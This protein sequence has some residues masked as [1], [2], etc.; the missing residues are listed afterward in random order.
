M[1]ARKSRPLTAN[2]R[3]NKPWPEWAAAEY[4]TALKAARLLRQ[5]AK[6]AMQQLEDMT[7]WPDPDR[8]QQLVSRLAIHAREAELAACRTE[9]A[10]QEHRQERWPRWAIEAL[11]VLADRG[12]TAARKAETAMS[13]LRQANWKG[14]ESSLSYCISAGQQMELLL[15]SGPPP[16]GETSD[17]GDNR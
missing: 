17:N 14:L 11:E 4:E 9:I 10:R 13:E 7:R 2:S 16:L 5:D 3:R 12:G 15:L 6:L 1:S 8:L